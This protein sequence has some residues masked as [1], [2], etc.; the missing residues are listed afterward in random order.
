MAVTKDSRQSAEERLLQESSLFNTH[1]YLL[2]NPDVAAA[3]M[4]PI[5]H[6]LHYGWHEGREPG[7]EFDTRYYLVQQPAVNMAPLLHY[8]LYGK[9]QGAI[10]KPH[11]CNTPW[12]WSI[13]PTSAE[14]PSCTARLARLTAW[15]TVIIPVYNAALAVKKCLDSVQAFTHSGCRV[16]IINDA[17]TDPAIIPLLKQYEAVPGFEVFTHAHNKGY[18]PTVNEGIALA[19]QADVILLNS[20]TCVSAGWVQ[21]LRWAACSHPK[22]A[23]VT[24]FSNN[25]G[26]FSAPAPGV[27]PLPQGTSLA[28]CA[29]A[30][31]QASGRYLPQV[32]T[33][34]GFCMYIRRAC[35]DDIGCFDEQAF[36]RGYGEENDFCMRAGAQ[37]WLHLIDDSTYIE[38]QRSASF[39]SN[40]EALLRAGGAVVNSRY[41][42]YT[43]QVR[44]AFSAP[45][46]QQ[47]RNRVDAALTQCTNI[48]SRILPRVLCVTTVNKMHLMQELSAKTETMVLSC[49][50][51]KMTLG[52]YAKGVYTQLAIHTLTQPLKSLSHQHEEY[53]AVIAS[54]LMQ[55][56]IEFVYVQ[57]T[58]THHLRVLE[59]AHL[60]GINGIFSHSAISDLRQFL[61]F[62]K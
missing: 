27:N 44:Q 52:H 8:L 12:W 51:Q 23:T 45:I 26:A 16:L 21:R 54:W 1:W 40:K 53:D 28:E 9:A 59:L 24:P 43:H 3:G 10:A 20:D 14:P 4:E 34:N 39:G 19:G 15:P 62:T 50:A 25:A 7:P 5:H 46:L 37:G 22:V 13:T 17:S 41:P 56:S 48:N 35:L 2:Q 6:Y 38:H 55:W 36:P 49:N 11:W 18:T 29:R 31:A 33:G 58:V 57:N 32:P 60:L 42:H 30:I 61:L 47:A